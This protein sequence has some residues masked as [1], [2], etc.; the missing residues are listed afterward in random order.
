MI[1]AKSSFC[2]TLDWEIM[3][4]LVMLQRRNHYPLLKCLFL[5]CFILWISPLL[6]IPF[7]QGIIPHWSFPTSIWPPSSSFLIMV[8]TK[9]IECNTIFFPHCS[10]MCHV[11]QDHENTQYCFLGMVH[12]FSNHHI[13]YME[14][15]IQRCFQKPTLDKRFEQ[16]RCLVDNLGSTHSREMKYTK[17]MGILQ[18]TNTLLNLAITNCVEGRIQENSKGMILN[19]QMEHMEGQTL[20]LDP[21]SNGL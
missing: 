1:V 2:T 4:L 13:Q 12:P 5:H 10:H 21:S 20:S 14:T 19:A 16:L 9:S 7:L 15:C 17:I 18:Y 3:Q 11:I 8:Q 6:N